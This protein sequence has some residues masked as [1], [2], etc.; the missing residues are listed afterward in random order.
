VREKN[1]IVRGIL[2]LGLALAALTP[3][4][5]GEVEDVLRQIPLKGVQS[6]DT[7]QKKNAPLPAGATTSTPRISAP[8][9]HPFVLKSVTI[10]GATVFPDDAFRDA[11]NDYLMHTVGASELARIA[12]QLTAVYR[13][14]GYFLSRAIIP[15]QDVADG[16]LKVQIIEGYIAEVVIEGDAPELANYADGLT[17][18]RPAR[19]AT[20]ERALYLMGDAAG[21]RFKASRMAPDG[22]DMARHKLIITA[23]RVPYELSLYTDNRGSPDAGEMQT[24][25]RAGTAHVINFADRLSAGYFFVPDQP[26]ELAFGELNYVTALG[27]DG[28][29]LTVNGSVSRN[30]QGDK[31]PGVPSSS[32][33]TRFFG[34][35]T[36]PIIRQRETS[37]WLHGGFERLHIRD[38]E[39]GLLGYKDDVVVAHAAATLR[40]RVWDGLATI[41]FEVSD[42]LIK[43]PDVV[44]S[45]A[46]ADGRF[47]KA[48]GQATLIEPLAWGFGL[49]VEVDGQASDRP[50]FS[51]EE[52]ALGGSRIGRGY[53][54]GEISGEDGVGGV[55]E[56][57]YYEKLTDWLGA[58]VYGFYDAGIVW[59]DNMPADKDSATLNSTGAGLRFSLPYS[60]Y[61]TYEA[62]KPLTR[63]PAVPGDKD[64]RNFFSLS[65]SL[66]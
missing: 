5:A 35:I 19:L 40:Q 41:Y 2:A 22:G 32:E 14:A 36:Y 66:Q 54:T 61:L 21:V 16:H 38:I 50:L 28:A 49:F 12:E 17:R 57:R 47:V 62:A 26:E 9:V 11:Y 42:G 48:F 30:D 37:L 31:A 55:I 8:G 6:D 3:A 39:D 45:R 43:A 63:T 34:Q 7:E 25:V 44:H 59:N 33:S 4:R 29:T 1:F 10:E 52:F 27:Y 24:Y 20:L 18:E 15:A 60:L 51:A 13:R 56:L 53:D 64:V 58:Q 23:E 46:D 65:W